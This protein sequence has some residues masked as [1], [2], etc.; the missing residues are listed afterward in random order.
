MIRNEQRLNIGNYITD[1]QSL[2]L[3]TVYAFDN[4]SDKISVLNSLITD[5]IDRHAPLRKVKITR[6][7]APWM[8]DLDISKLQWTRNAARVKY[9]NDPSYRHHEEL[10]TVRNELKKSIKE[11]KKAFLKKLFL[12]KNCSETWKVINKILHPNPSTVKVNPDEVNIQLF[13]PDSHTND[14]KRSR[15][16]HR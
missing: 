8:K 16:N 15:K 5:C 9:R 11:T 7:P 13:Q 6:P 2:P 4:A 3:S 14:G 10:K 1:F 12:N